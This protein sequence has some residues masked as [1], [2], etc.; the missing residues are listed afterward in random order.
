[1]PKKDGNEATKEIRDFERQSIPTPIPCKKNKST[2]Q[3]ASILARSIAQKTAV[4][5]VAVSANTSEADQRRA[6]ECGVD[7]FIGK[8]Y[9]KSNIMEV[10]SCM[11]K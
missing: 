10:L 5:I 6:F 3:P 9:N 11:K 1:M 8:P 4:N 7:S 2:K